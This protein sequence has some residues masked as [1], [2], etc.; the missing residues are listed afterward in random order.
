MKVSS[1][2]MFAFIERR[3]C[4]SRGTKVVLLILLSIL[5]ASYL[6]KGFWIE[7]FHSSGRFPGAQDLSRRWLEQQYIFRGLDP[8][9]ALFSSKGSGP[10]SGLPV[11]I[12]AVYPPW[13][14]FSG[15]FFFWP[16]WP[17]VRIWYGLINLL[18][19]AYIIHFL[20]RFTRDE[21]LF[22]RVFFILSITSISAFCT[23]IGT[24]NYG[25]IVLALL[26]G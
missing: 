24:G 14:Y 25:V 4:R 20:I 7:L 5:S 26:F 18:C 19:L 8:Y 17:Y 21:R 16:R 13:S 9:N 6:G 2:S 15:F 22:D 11:P 23:T 12:D 1:R 3:L 10:P